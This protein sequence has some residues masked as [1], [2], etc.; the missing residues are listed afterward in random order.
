MDT[1][2]EEGPDVAAFPHFS[3]FM[4]PGFRRDDSEYAGK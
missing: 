1:E 4:G 2:L 3:V